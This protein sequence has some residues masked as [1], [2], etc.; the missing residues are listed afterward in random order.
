MTHTQ[1]GRNVVQLKAN[2][3][4]KVLLK[5]LSVELLEKKSL[6]TNFFFSDLSFRGLSLLYSQTGGN[7]IDS[8]E[9]QKNI[10]EQLQW[11]PLW[12]LTPRRIMHYVKEITEKWKKGQPVSLTDFYGHCV[13][14]SLLGR[15][16][17]SNFFLTF[18]RTSHSIVLKEILLI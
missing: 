13:G 11:G 6:E 12:L 4:Y 1:F 5:S 16:S 7:K 8:T 15:V 9:T 10:R 3:L 2:V 14:E 17:L 18:N